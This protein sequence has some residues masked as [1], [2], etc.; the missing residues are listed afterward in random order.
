MSKQ[1]YDD[2]SADYDRFVNWEERL[3]VEMPFILEK[4]RTA[5]LEEDRPIR[6]LDA[7]CGT[8]MHAI[9][10][11]KA[12]M[13]VSGADLS[14]EMIRVAKTNARAAQS[15]VEFKTAG[16]GVLA[17]TFAG[18]SSFPYDAVICLG[19][20]LPH[21]LSPE[22]I[23]DT[24]ADMAKCLGPGGLLLL[25][26]RN[27]DAVMAEKDRWLGTQSHVE[28]NQE[29]LFLRFYD[30][31]SDGLITFNIIRLHR[32]DDGEWKEQRS[33]TRLF[34]L[35][36]E[37]LLDLLDKAGLN[38]ISCFGKMGNDTFDPKDSGNLV[39]IAEKKQIG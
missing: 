8:G 33:A 38:Q 12:G 16:F 6:V 31:D 15:S 9:A 23:M 34:P 37:L 29:W 36:Q 3:P 2:F 30:F 35:R 14:A 17:E 5:A 21:L 32:V 4:L 18:S 10:L 7:A 19:N 1:A 39:I 25:Q 13:R 27:F 20:S 28:G 26:N 22:S 11:A 24:L